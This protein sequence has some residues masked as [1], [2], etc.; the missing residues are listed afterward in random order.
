MVR[1]QTN[2]ELEFKQLITFTDV[3]D[4]NSKL[5][6]LEEKLNQERKSCLLLLKNKL[7]R[8]LPTRLHL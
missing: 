2:D 3:N 1:K 4:L 6:E 7:S 8:W 5:K